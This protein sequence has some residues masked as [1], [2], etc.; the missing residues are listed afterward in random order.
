MF[1]YYFLQM[2][3][4]WLLAV[5]DYCQGDAE[6]SLEEFN[7]SFLTLIQVKNSDIFRRFWQ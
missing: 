2:C 5:R 3:R 7:G 6:M 1:V 4:Y